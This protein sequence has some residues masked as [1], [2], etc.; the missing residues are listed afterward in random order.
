MN[1]PS[2]AAVAAF[3]LHG[4]TPLESSDLLRSQRRCESVRARSRTLASTDAG[5]ALP[6]A[7]QHLVAAHAPSTS[8]LLSSWQPH[9]VIAP[10]LWASAPGLS[11]GASP[12]HEAALNLNFPRFR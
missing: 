10:S 11:D 8:R 9:L 2:S 1:L 5:H 12:S 6:L 3:A 7:G 4:A